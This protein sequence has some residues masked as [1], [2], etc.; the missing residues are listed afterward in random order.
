[1]AQSSLLKGVAITGLDTIPPTAPTVG[2]GAPGLL[3]VVNDY[4]TAVSADDTGSRYRICRFPTNA[5]VKRVIINSAV[6]SAGAADINVAYSDSTVDGTPPSLATLTDPVVIIPSNDN[7]LFGA[8]QS[9]VGTGLAVDQTWLGTFTAKMSNQPM[10][11]NLIDLGT[12]QFTADPGG[13]FDIYL[14]VTTAV[15]TG[16][17]VACKV[18]YVI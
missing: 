12:T 15:T 14:V 1:M 18:E 2:E 11:Q 7:K 5:K 13:Y 3:R 16:G 9:I 17:V 6:A 4:V 10:W 8:A